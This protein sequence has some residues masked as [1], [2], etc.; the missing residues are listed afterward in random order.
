MGIWQ[1]IQAWRERRSPA[2][3]VRRL[4]AEGAIDDEML[5]ASRGLHPSQH[6][7]KPYRRAWDHWP[8]RDQHGH[9]ITEERFAAVANWIEITTFDDFAH[10]FTRW[11]EGY[12]PE[13]A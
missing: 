13:R 1:R 2:A 8:K 7:A 9:L 5:L 4:Y 11:I 10:G 12:N 3:L 6:S